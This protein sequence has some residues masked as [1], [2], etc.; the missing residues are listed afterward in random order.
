MKITDAH[1]YPNSFQKMRVKLATQLLSNSMSATIQTCIQTGQLLN[2]TASN[3]ADFIEFINNLFDCLNSRFLYS[4]NLYLCALT[5]SGTVIHFL[6]EASQY[7]TDL[8][9]LKKGKLTQPPC[10][11]G[12]KQTINGVLQFFEE[13]K[14]NDIVF[15]M[16]NRL[17]QD[18][19]ENLFSIFRQKGGY[20]KNSTARTIRTSIRSNCIFS[21]CTSTRTNC[22]KLLKN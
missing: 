7:F 11:K 4:H 5:D 6:L 15:L 18:V 3:T 19:L 16:T 14:S 10:F 21:L 1:I 22:E 8:H 20:N 17:N 12:F 13:E 2:S 9:K